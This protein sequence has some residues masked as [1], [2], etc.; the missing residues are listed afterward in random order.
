M[1]NAERIISVAEALCEATKVAMERDSKIYVIGEGVTD[2][3]AIFETTRG[4]L[5]AFGPKRV[6]EMPVAENGLTGIAIGSAMMGRKPLMVHQRVDFAM[7]SLEQLFNNAAKAYYA[8]NGK[9]S[10]PL[11]VRMIIG[12]GWGQGPAHSQ[13]LESL[14]ASIPGLKVVMPTTA[15]EAKGQLI[16]ALED[17]N[18]IMF[19]EHRWVHYV[20]GHVPTGYYTVPLTS[21]RVRDGNDVTIV[22]TSY[23]LFE[24]MMAA[25]FLA[26]ANIS[27]EIIDLAVLR[28][29]DMTPI[30]DS[31]RK[32]GRL[33]TADTGFRTL[34]MGAELVAEVACRD[35]SCLLAP[36]VRVGLPDHPTPSSRSL[37]IGYY[38]TAI[39]VFDAAVTTCGVAPQTVATI[40]ERLATK[41]NALPSDVPTPAFKGPF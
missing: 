2:P 27:A 30:M 23:M 20:T 17:G 19:L 1:P 22:A 39:D 29:L 14:F 34:G 36:P 25:D 16:A 12:R 7:L 3:K 26:E 37:A 13:S 8:S 41:R 18:P 15:Y 33:V 32:T 40:R 28:P 35:M 11:V 10:V 5:D 24:A 9:H 38:R 31:V 21:R 4:L 6:I